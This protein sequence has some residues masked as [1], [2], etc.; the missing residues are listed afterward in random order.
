MHDAC[1]LCSLV[2]NQCLAER[3]EAYE[4]DKRTLTAYD[5]IKNLPQKKQEI[6]RLKEVHSQVLRKMC[7]GA[8]IRPSMASSGDSKPERSLATRSSD[9]PGAMTVSPIRSPVST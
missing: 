4:A 6:P 3:K 9:Q 7:P 1:F 8:S 2:Y 5:Q